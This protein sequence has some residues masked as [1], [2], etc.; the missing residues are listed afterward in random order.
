MYQRVFIVKEG[1][2]GLMKPEEYESI[3][4]LYKEVLE[5]AEDTKGN[6]MAEVEVVETT[7]EAVKRANME[8][9][10]VVF[11]SRGMEEEAEKLASAYPR[12][13]VVVFTGAI[14]QGKVIW[15]NKACAAGM[16][17]IQNIVLRY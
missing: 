9:D 3:I 11:I 2:W 4:K 15:V 17:T 10:V 7:K 14:P 13:K 6:K 8:A 12:I 5:R 1:Q 16:E